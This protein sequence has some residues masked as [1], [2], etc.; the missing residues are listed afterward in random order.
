MSHIVACDSSTLVP[1]L[2]ISKASQPNEGAEPWDIE[3]VYHRA[4]DA[5]FAIPRFFVF[6][7]IIHCGSLL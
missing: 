3:N 6:T 2:A 5:I 4:C 7:S 1:V